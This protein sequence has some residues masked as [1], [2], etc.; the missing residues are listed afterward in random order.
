MGEDDGDVESSSATLQQTEEGFTPVFF[1]ARP[2][3]NLL[4]VDELAS[5]M[6]ITD[7]KVGSRSRWEGDCKVVDE[8]MTL[9][10]WCYV[11]G[12]GGIK[13]YRW[14]DTGAEALTQPCMNCKGEDKG[15]CIT[16]FTGILAASMDRGTVGMGALG[17]LSVFGADAVPQGR[18]C[19]R[20]YG[21]AVCATVALGQ[22][23]H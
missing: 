20:S 3:K 10:T 11:G 8:L 14:H 19:S 13:H 15:T 21:S 5:L 1:D 6:P 16:V 17:Q 12:A 22:R 18:R 4:L 2:L 23:T 7:M 9:I